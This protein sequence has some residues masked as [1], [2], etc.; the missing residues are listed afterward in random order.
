MRQ[1]LQLDDRWNCLSLSF[2]FS[3]Y[4]Q[5]LVNWCPLIPVLTGSDFIVIVVWVLLEFILSKS[6]GFD[7]FGVFVL[8]PCNGLCGCRWKCVSGIDNS[9]TS[10]RIWF[11]V[12]SFTFNS[13]IVLFFPDKFSGVSVIPMCFP[14]SELAITLV[15]SRPHD[16]FFDLI[17]NS[18]LGWII[19]FIAVKIAFWN[20]SS[21]V[22]TILP[23]SVSILSLKHLS[24]VFKFT[25]FSLTAW[26]PSELPTVNSWST[27]LSL[28]VV[29]SCPMFI[30]L[31]MI[32][33][34]SQ[35]CNWL[36]SFLLDCL[37]LWVETMLVLTNQLYLKQ[38]N[39]WRFDKAI[40]FKSITSV[41]QTI[42]LNKGVI[43]QNEDFE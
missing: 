20:L 14:R 31:P 5:P 24:K 25:T 22:A 30:A 1:L 7:L 23:F 43:T 41:E 3:V 32:T 35:S 18:T 12:S 9:L 34:W 28:T 6:Q 37:F 42:L 27:V 10:S 29:L 11:R 39:Q 36:R 38:W 13:W 33:S 2:D 40:K 16:A 8:S 21:T 26:P 17:A 4:V 19:L 15:A